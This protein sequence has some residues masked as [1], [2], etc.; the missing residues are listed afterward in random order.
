MKSEEAPWTDGGV[1]G[2]LR[3]RLEATA[4][5]VAAEWGV[6]LG[7]PFP[8]AHYSYAAPAGEDA[9]LKV[10]RVED[11]E[12]DHECDALALWDGPA[13]SGC[14]AATRRVARCCSSVPGQ[15]RTRRS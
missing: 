11:D 2:W 5:E 4:R 10:T 9:V 12:A 3:A 6:T 8:W 13:P 14:Y 7:D 15:A 1:S